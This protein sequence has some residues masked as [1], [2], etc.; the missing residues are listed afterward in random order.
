M[1][2]VHKFEDLEI[3]QLA[4]TIYKKVSALTEKM[5]AKHDYRFCGSNESSSWFCYG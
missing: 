4:F 3:W 2:T 5:R 1:A